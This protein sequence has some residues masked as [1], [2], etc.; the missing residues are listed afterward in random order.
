MRG[1]LHCLLNS[2]SLIISDS[3]LPNVLSNSP[4]ILRPSFIKWEEA[5]SVCPSSPSRKHSPP[6]LQPY[7][8]TGTSL[9]IFPSLCTRF[10]LL[11]S[12]LKLNC[13]LSISNTQYLVG[14]HT[15]SATVDLSH[16]LEI[17]F[18]SSLP[19][20]EQDIPGAGSVSWPRGDVGGDKPKD[21]DIYGK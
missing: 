3:G 13:C 10:F 11:P 17:T 20:G 4:N 16:V 12:L 5:A 18:L 8:V 9:C 19:T 1:L 21:L 6:S 14:Q 15:L 7:S 2:W